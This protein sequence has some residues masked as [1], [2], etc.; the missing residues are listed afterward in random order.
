MIRKIFLQFSK[1]YKG[2]VSQHS[3]P[4]KMVLVRYYRVLNSRLALTRQAILNP[5]KILR[6]SKQNVVI[7]TFIETTAQPVIAVICCYWHDASIAAGDVTGD[8]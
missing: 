5:R 6:Y 4:A 1:V 2:D 7:D 8:A 3:K